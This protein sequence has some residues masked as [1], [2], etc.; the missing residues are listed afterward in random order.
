MNL[1]QIG[2]FSII[3]IVIIG[4]PAIGVW[5]ARN[6]KKKMNE[7]LKTK[8]SMIGSINNGLVQIEGRV[9]PTS[10]GQLISPLSGTPCVAYICN[11]LE[12]TGS[13]KTRSYTMLT[14]EQHSTQFFVEDSTGKIIVDPS[15]A[16][17][18]KYKENNYSIS[19]FGGPDQKVASFLS[20]NGI[21]Y[22]GFLGL[23]RN[24]TCGELLIPIGEKVFVKG[25][26]REYSETDLLKIPDLTLG[27]KFIPCM[28]DN[29]ELTNIAVGG[30]NELIK[31]Y[32]N[33]FWL[34]IIAILFVI[35][36]FITLI[37]ITVISLLR[38]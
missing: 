24:I 28:D 36:F 18:L 15:Q 23:K 17:I 6:L 32:K 14:S 31:R 10:L 20:K 38:M 25:K 8:N 30:E 9:V 33:Q 35:G 5:H 26:A 13:G 22:K 27:Q 37:S 4:L 21:N 11:A 3:G 7:I 2:V 12:A 34:T 16:N 1:D 19:F 29:G